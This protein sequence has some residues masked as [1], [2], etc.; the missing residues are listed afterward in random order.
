M[1]PDLSAI[2]DAIRQTVKAA[3]DDIELVL[4]GILIVEVLETGVEVPVLR[5]LDIG[6]PTTW[7]KAGMLHAAMRSVDADLDNGYR[8]GE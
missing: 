8:P 7:A 5:Y 3:F 4:N 6:L 1:D 2:T